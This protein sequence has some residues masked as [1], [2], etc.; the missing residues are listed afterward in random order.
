MR[1][2]VLIPSLLVFG[3]LRR[4]PCITNINPGK[5]E[6]SNALPQARTELETIL[7]ESKTQRARQLKLP[8]EKIPNSSSNPSGDIGREKTAQWEGP[9][10]FSKFSKNIISVTD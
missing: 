7:E 1:L 6:T 2:N 9:I 10:T 3:T 5:S 8:R 4:F